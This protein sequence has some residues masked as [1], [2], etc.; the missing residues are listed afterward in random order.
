[1]RNKKSE[2]CNPKCAIRR[3]Y[4]RSIFHL[5]P[6][7]LESLEPTWQ[8]E[9]ELKKRAV[10]VIFIIKLLEKKEFIIDERF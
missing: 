3:T 1:M 2:I 5:N 4:E 6:R 7:A 8:G 10:M 9:K